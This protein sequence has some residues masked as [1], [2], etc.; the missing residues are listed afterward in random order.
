MNVVPRISEACG[1]AVQ[2]SAM[3]ASKRFAVRFAFSCKLHAGWYSQG[4]GHE[5]QRRFRRRG[6]KCRFPNPAR[7]LGTLAKL[8]S[9]G[10]AHMNVASADK[11][12]RSGHLNNLSP[13]MAPEF[14]TKLIT[15]KYLKSSSSSGKDSPRASKSHSPRSRSHSP[16]VAPTRRE[17]KQAGYG[18]F[19]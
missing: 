4:Q 16:R 14:D 17:E 15:P 18:I 8:N 5:L 13:R 9:S 2:V 10:R 12:R 11:T 6:R 3:T 19:V 1:G 7:A